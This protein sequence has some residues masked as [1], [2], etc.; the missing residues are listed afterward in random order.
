MSRLL[1]LVTALWI[2]MAAAFVLPVAYTAAD[3][4]GEARTEADASPPPT[5]TLS[6]TP[7]P[8]PSA[9]PT[10]SPMP[11]EPPQP[12]PSASPTPDGLQPDPSVT[13]AVAVEQE[14]DLRTSLAA[15]PATIDVGGETTIE[16]VVTNTGDDAAEDVDVIATLPKQLGFSSAKPAP[17][18]ILTRRGKTTLVFS[19]LVVPADGSLTLAVVA[20]GLEETNEPAV[21]VA[22]ALWRGIEATGSTSVTVETPDS[23]LVVDTDGPGLL[24]QVGDRVRYGI[25]VRNVGAAAAHQ[26]S[27]VNLVP[28]EVHVVAA[29]LAPGVDAVQVG[30]AGDGA[31]DVVWALDDLDA[32]EVVRV[33]Y[34]GVVDEPGD[35][36]AVNHTRVLV[37][38]AGAGRARERTYLATSGG[39]RLRNPGFDPV[40][41]KKIVREPVTERPLIRKRL[42]TDTATPEADSDTGTGGT[43]SSGAL[44]YTGIDP[45]GIGV[46]GVTLIGSGIVFVRFA[47]RWRRRGAAVPIALLVLLAGACVSNDAPGPAVAPSPSEQG[48]TRVK[49]KQIIRPEGDR[50]TP[51]GESDAGAPATGDDVNESGGSVDRATNDGE[52]DGTNPSENTPGDADDPAIASPDLEDE[53]VLVPGPPVTRLERRVRFVTITE[54][55][56]PVANLESVS[57]ADEMSFTWDD[58]SSNIT[59]AT[60]STS[61]GKANLVQLS[62]ETAPSGPGMQATVTLRNAAAR[63]RV[64]VSGTL[65]LEITGGGLKATL[66]GDVVDVVLNPGGESVSAFTFRLPSGSYEARPVFRTD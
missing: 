27:I 33:S 49:G 15:V 9:V 37:G 40:T 6:P 45:W 48:D 51:P 58:A 12:S 63:A 53:T 35:L 62:T 38:R 7:T 61:T 4:D 39:Q 46:L 19:S 41:V 31:E 34:S 47:S 16:V 24:A 55:D 3:D 30:Q 18:S 66:T 36:E 26:V 13:P 28:T 32:G 14:V 54:G 52:P 43:F 64:A 56:L 20:E 2:S 59:S 8:S 5:P 44:P 25:T 17:S 57:D 1:R 50:D 42:A 10:P 22:S 60:S 11:S 29:G 65:G 23:T 21:V